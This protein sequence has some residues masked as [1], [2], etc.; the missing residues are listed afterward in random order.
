VD[1]NDR[2]RTAAGIALRHFKQDHTRIVENLFVALKQEKEERIKATLI[3]DI[4]ELATPEQCIHLQPWLSDESPRVRANAIEI[5]SRSGNRERLKTVLLTFMRDENNRVRANTCV[6]L[7][8]LGELESVNSLIEMTQSTNHLPRA[9]GAWGLSEI[10]SRGIENSQ[11]NQLLVTEETVLQLDRALE[12]LHQ[13]LA[14]QHPMV[15]SNVVKGLGRIGNHQSVVKLINAFHN[16]EDD[17]IRML[18]L[19]AL[20]QIGSYRVVRQLKNQV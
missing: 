17:E 18:I 12:V 15:L 5:M 14:D 7:F 16:M 8:G 3:M 6:T 9:S 1:E 11:T 2:I 19:G 13:L 10:A 4:G 20:D